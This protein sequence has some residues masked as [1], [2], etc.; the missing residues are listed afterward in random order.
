MRANDFTKTALTPKT[1][2]HMHVSRRSFTVIVIANNNRRNSSRFIGAR[3]SRNRIV[4][5][6]KL[7]LTEFVFD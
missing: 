1:R 7:I 5:A 3:N 4:G 6:G 2:L